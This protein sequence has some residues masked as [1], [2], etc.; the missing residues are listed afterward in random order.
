M[1]V[2]V[3]ADKAE[4]ALQAIHM[5]GED[6]FMIGEMVARKDEAVILTGSDEAFA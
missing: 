5:T 4:D 6:A 2:Y 3:S 1:L